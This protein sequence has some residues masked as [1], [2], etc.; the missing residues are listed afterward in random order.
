MA[1]QWQTA[2][3]HAAGT[4]LSGTSWSEL[5]HCLKRMEPFAQQRQRL[6]CGSPC[7]EDTG[8]ESQMVSHSSSG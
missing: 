8:Q 4:A 5:R 7:S 6:H 1:V 2:P 3:L